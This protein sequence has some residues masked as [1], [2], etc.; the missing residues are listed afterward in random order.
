[1]H[2]GRRS[3]L[4]RV[5]PAAKSITKGLQ[6]D[7]LIFVSD[8]SKARCMSGVTGG[9]IVCRFRTSSSPKV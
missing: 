1:M 8:L 3:A 2:L 9:Q 4:A 7:P 5:K 6:L